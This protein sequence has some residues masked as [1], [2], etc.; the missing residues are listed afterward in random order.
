MKKQIA[1]I[2][3][4]NLDPVRQDMIDMYAEVESKQRQEAIG[5]TKTTTKTGDPFTDVW[6]DPQNDAQWAQSRKLE[7][8]QTILTGTHLR[9][10]ILRTFQQDYVPYA[11][12]SSDAEVAPSA[13]HLP[14]GPASH[15]GATHVK[16]EDVVAP[17]FELKASDV[18]ALTVPSNRASRGPS[19][20]LARN[21]LIQSWTKRYRSD[22]EVVKS[23]GDPQV[24]LNP[25]QMRAIAMMLSERLS[26]VQGV[27]AD[28]VIVV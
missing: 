16:L 5:T 25:S 15:Q 3:S 7:V 28:A 23:D 17:P 19:G 11:S 22:G 27:S 9:D 13:A 4:M 20:V 21:Q 10:L 8:D 24:P 2:R 26:L 14:H 12:K 1:A 18:D 6:N